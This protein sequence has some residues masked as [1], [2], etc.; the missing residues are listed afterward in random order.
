MPAEKA[1]AGVGMRTAIG[2]EHAGVMVGFEQERDLAGSLHDVDSAA[3][4]R[5]RWSTAHAQLEVR[6]RLRRAAH[7]LGVIKTTGAPLGGVWKQPIRRI[8][9]P[10]RRPWVR[11]VLRRTRTRHFTAGTRSDRPLAKALRL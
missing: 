2:V 8:D 9:D 4:P 11:Q 6:E 1:D 10:L 7:V 5:L 3:R